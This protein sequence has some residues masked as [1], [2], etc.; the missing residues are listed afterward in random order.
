[1]EDTGTL[2]LHDLE[3]GDEARFPDATAY[4]L[5][6]GGELLLYSYEP[7][8]GE[9]PPG[10]RAVRPASG[11]TITLLD[12]PGSYPQLAVDRE[13][14]QAAFLHAPEDA[15][16]EAGEDDDAEHAVHLW[17]VGEAAAARAV[18][19]GLKKKT[20]PPDKGCRGIPD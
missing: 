16:A 12:G 4:A 8:E 6:E 18:G 15:D 1:V 19:G 7:A 2:I 11:E 13:G 5:A 20:R 9:G 10:V 14:R 3:T 17:R